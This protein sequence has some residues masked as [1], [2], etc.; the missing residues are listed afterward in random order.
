M[1]LIIDNRVLRDLVKGYL[2]S[3]YGHGDHNNYSNLP[4]EL[5]TII[6]NKPI[7]EWDVSKVTDMS[8]LFK[9]A[10]KFD[11]PLNNWDISNVIFM[12]EMFSGCS[13]FNQ[14][15]YNWNTKNVIN[16]EDM[17]CDCKI[18]NQPFQT[19]W[20]NWNTS[21]VI[22]M[23]NMFQR[24]D[25]FNQPLQNWDTSNVKN[26]DGMFAQS[27]K[28]DQSLNSWDTSNVTDMSNMFYD[29]SAF[30]NPLNNWITTNVTDMKGMFFNN[31]NFNQS[32]D[33]WDTS[34]VIN[35]SYMFYGSSYNCPL[36]NWVVSN[37]RNMSSM[38]HEAKRFNQHLN[39]WNVTNVMNM[40]K[41]FE[42]SNYNQSLSSWKI[43]IMCEYKSLLKNTPI[44]YIQ[45]KHPLIIEYNFLNSDDFKDYFDSFNRLDTSHKEPFNQFKESPIH[46]II[47]DNESKSQGFLSLIQLYN[48]SANASEFVQ[49]IR[50]GIIQ[51]YFFNRD[52]P[53]NEG[54]GGIGIF[55]DLST[56]MMDKISDL[57]TIKPC[58][59]EKDIESERTKQKREFIEVLN[60]YIKSKNYPEK[61]IINIFP[62]I[63]FAYWGTKDIGYDFGLGLKDIYKYIKTNDKYRT[64]LKDL[65]T[66]NKNYISYILADVFKLSLYGTAKQKYYDFNRTGKE[67]LT[68]KLYRSIHNYLNITNEFNNYITESIS[69]KTEKITELTKKIN[70]IDINW[71]KD[72]LSMYNAIYNQICALPLVE[73]EK[74]IMKE[75]KSKSIKFINLC[76]SQ[77]N[78]YKYLK[79]QLNK[80]QDPEISS[81]DVKI[82]TIE[83]C[84]DINDFL[85]RFSDKFNDRLK[86][87]LNDEK[88]KKILETEG[89]EIITEI[90]KRINSLKLSDLEADDDKMEGLIWMWC[91]LFDSYKTG[92]SKGTY[93]LFMNLIH[94]NKGK[95]LFDEDSDYNM[96]YMY[97]DYQS[98]INSESMK[99]YNFKLGFDL[100]FK[101]INN[102]LVQSKR[103]ILDLS[104]I[105]NYFD[106]TT[107]FS[108]EKINEFI[109]KI[110][111]GKDIPEI[112]KMKIIRLL[113]NY[114]DG[115]SESLKEKIKKKYPTQS[116]FFRQVLFW[117]SGSF[118]INYEA[119]K[120]GYTIKR[121]DVLQYF[122]PH[123]CFNGLDVNPKFISDNLN[124]YDKFVAE[125]VETITNYVNK[126]GGGRMIGNKNNIPIR[127]NIKSNKLKKLQISKKTKRTKKS[128]KSERITRM[129]KSKK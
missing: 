60:N 48:M 126:S 54:S 45:S 44:E 83:V 41:M 7:G 5:K 129:R 69:K 72:D 91:I 97:E 117:W 96:K 4:E 81:Y 102:S 86:T 6:R 106:K 99:Y 119:T 12:Q 70:S 31:K 46:I 11:Q 8:S 18:F 71:I 15:L 90:Y 101:Y 3:N 22:N 103:N 105:Y 59:L 49:N 56:Y 111:W 104:I 74:D 17:F 112:L 128:K 120:E 47:P 32:L 107:D 92:F 127:K 93:E 29:C 68:E 115:I 62:Y 110:T 13:K 65:D 113:R 123:A 23:K 87:Y 34:N 9:I 88:I 20:G 51:T 40:S 52:G 24:C 53:R 77:I 85:T 43:N 61:D 118:R 89:N 94:T 38:F 30:N 114:E 76:N 122:W 2:A 80:L 109:E 78:N 75:E 67:E 66:K 100:L 98:K 121:T 82:N 63:H 10:K 27:P 79:K 57:V 39:N 124:T 28:F 36:N 16:M 26:M 116:D 21:N 25:D 33:N 14:P 125:F 50:E 19:E 1:S 55:K 108:E 95:E 84:V 37:V 35:M 58:E 42:D 73:Q 64:M